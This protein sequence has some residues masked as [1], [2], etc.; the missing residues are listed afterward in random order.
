MKLFK[1][2]I[3]TL[4]GA[5]LIG[6]TTAYK[7]IGEDRIISSSDDSFSYPSWALEQ[8]RYVNGET[9]FVSGSV[10]IDVSQSPSQGLEAAGLIARAHLAEEVKSRLQ[11][12]MQYASEGLDVKS[13]TLQRIVNQEASID[14]LIG[15]YVSKRWYAKVVVPDADGQKLVRYR[16]FTLVALPMNVY[17]AQI[18]EALSEAASNGKLSQE[19]RKRA[20]ESWEMFFGKKEDS[21]LNVQNEVASDQ[22]AA[23]EGDGK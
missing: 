14:R 16:C 21:H 6:C 12:Q 5:T 2:I 18:A 3:C 19:F 11:S 4:T 15:S 20:T 9:M 17:R 23:V 8:T 1:L 22:V 7:G 13:Q 10:E